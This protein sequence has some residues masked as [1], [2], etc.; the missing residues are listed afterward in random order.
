MFE[1]V[2]VKCWYVV[3]IY[4]GYENKVKKNLEKRVEFMNM[5]E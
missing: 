1:E 4:F 2:G 5:I 3:Y